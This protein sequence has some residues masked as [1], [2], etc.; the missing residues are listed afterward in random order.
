MPEE[1]LALDKCN[2]TLNSDVISVI[3]EFLSFRKTLRPVFH[4]WELL[5]GDLITGN[6]KEYIKKHTPLV[7]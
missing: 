6:Y 4:S 2:E 7:L 1:I 3:K 5:H